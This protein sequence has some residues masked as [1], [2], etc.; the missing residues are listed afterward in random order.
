MPRSTF[1]QT[2][3]NTDFSIISP[4]ARNAVWGGLMTAGALA[5]RCLGTIVS[6]RIRDTSEHRA[7]SYPLF[8]RGTSTVG[9]SPFTRPSLVDISV[10]IHTGGN[11]QPVTVNPGDWLVADIDGV[12][13]VP[14]ELAKQVAE[15]AAGGH[16]VDA[17]CL[18]DIQKGLGVANSFNMHRGK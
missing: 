8:A 2:Y 9:Q 13:C 15:L 4:E 5:R 1:H 18:E 16:D 14:K 3:F 7:T 12:V 11:L 17:R 6:G 10:T